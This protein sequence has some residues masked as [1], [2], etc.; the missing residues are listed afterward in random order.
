MGACEDVH[1]RRVTGSLCMYDRLI[2]KGHL[3]C[4]YKQDGARCYLWTQGWG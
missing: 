4:L 3:T 2:F 1:A